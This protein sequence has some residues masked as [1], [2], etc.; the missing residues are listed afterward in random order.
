MFRRIKMEPIVIKMESKAAFQVKTQAKFFVGELLPSPSPSNSAEKETVLEVPVIV[1]APAEQRGHRDSK[2]QPFPAAAAAA[3]AAAGAVR[4]RVGGSGGKRS[5]GGRTYDGYASLPSG[6]GSARR[7]YEE[8]M[9]EEDAYY[10]ES[11]FGGKRREGR[12][13]N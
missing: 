6:A 12:C 2:R 13:V 4:S 9:E 3:S 1:E 5:T 11:E 8:E 7:D 10:V